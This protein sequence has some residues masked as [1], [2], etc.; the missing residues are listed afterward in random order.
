MRGC[1]ATTVNMATGSQRVW[2]GAKWLSQFCHN[3]NMALSS[4]QTKSLEL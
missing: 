3:N 1:Y 4:R 2:D